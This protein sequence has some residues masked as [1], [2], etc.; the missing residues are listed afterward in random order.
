MEMANLRLPQ[1]GVDR[2]A[3]AEL[4]KEEGRSMEGGRRPA[5]HSTWI[6]RKTQEGGHPV[7]VKMPRL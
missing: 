5:E 3:F 2:V 6:L 4:G 1:T 7:T